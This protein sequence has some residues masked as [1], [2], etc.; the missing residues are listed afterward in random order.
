[1]KQHPHPPDAANPA[2][3]SRKLIVL[4]VFSWLPD[5]RGLITFPAPEG[6][7]EV[8][9]NFRTTEVRSISDVISFISFAIAAPML[10]NHKKRAFSSKIP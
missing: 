7:S 8:E 1:M 6:K 2:W 3:R 4:M 9:V 10:V 5:W